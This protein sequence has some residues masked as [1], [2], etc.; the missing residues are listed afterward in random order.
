[1]ATYIGQNLTQGSRQRVSYTA[2]LNQTTF[3]AGYA[4]GFV[5]VYQNGLLLP[6][7]EYTATNGS[8]VV[9]NTGAALNDEIEIIGQFLFAVE[10]TVSSSSGGTFS[11][12]VNINSNL[13]VSGYLAGP[14]TFT[15][16]PAVVGDNTGTVVIAG[17]LQVDGTTTTINSTTL[18]VDDLNI[19]VASGAADAAAANGAGITVDGASATLTYVNAGDNW[20]FNKDLN[21]D[22]DLTVGGGQINMPNVATKDKY[23]VWNNSTYAIGMDNNISFGGLATEYAMTFQMNDQATRGFWWGDNAHTD[24]QGAMAL[25]TQGKLTV[26]HSARIGYGETDTTTPGAT[27]ALDVNGSIQDDKGDVREVSINNSISTTPFVVPAGS[28]GELYQLVSGAS[29]VNINAANFSQG[30]IVTIYNHTG[31]TKTITFNTW[32]NSVR[33]AGSSTNYSGTSITLAAYGIASFICPVGNR[34]VVNG[35]VS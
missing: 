18:D 9:L 20:S 13:T 16:D 5:D 33:I 27:H 25:T 1:M 11:G 28:S 35:N 17:N 3:S 29:V 15:I 24:A 19:T 32:S 22:G 7:S 21:L 8:T 23:R 2:T 6:T 12:A 30:D 34:M 4:P 31:S 14:A 26:A 10:D